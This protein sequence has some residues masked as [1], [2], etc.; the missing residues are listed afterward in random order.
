MKSLAAPLRLDPNDEPGRSLVNE[1][2]DLGIVAR[3]AV[4]LAA[5]SVVFSC[6]LFSPCLQFTRNSLST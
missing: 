4:K 1:S 3:V 2:D 5:E 6:H